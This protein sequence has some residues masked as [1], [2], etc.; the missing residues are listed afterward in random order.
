M[1]TVKVR[2]NRKGEKKH[3]ID[4]DH[5]SIQQPYVLCSKGSIRK[6]SESLSWPPA[7]VATVVSQFHALLTVPVC[8]RLFPSVPVCSRL[9][10]FP[11]FPVPIERRIAAEQN[12]ANHPTAPNITLLILRM[13]KTQKRSPKSKR[14]AFN[15][16]NCLV[17]SHN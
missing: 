12:V 14:Q 5:N 10:A 6:M 11:A 1:K 7:Q 9:P 13:Q 3:L 8:S 2:K 4:D 17:A 16:S 15:M